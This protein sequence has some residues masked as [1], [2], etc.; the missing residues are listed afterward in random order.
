MTFSR[1]I[2]IIIYLFKLFQLKHY[3]TRNRIHLFLHDVNRDV[4]SG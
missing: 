4:A 1:G 3:E 2:I